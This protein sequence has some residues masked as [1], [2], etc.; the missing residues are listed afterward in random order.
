MAVNTEAVPARPPWYQGRYAS[1]LVTTD[2]KRVGILYVSTSLLFFLGGGVLALLMRS[3]LATAN[4]HFIVRGSYDELFTLHGTTMI[5]LVVVPILAGFGNFHVPLNIGEDLGR[6]P[7]TD[8]DDL[9]GVDAV[10]VRLVVAE[11]QAPAAAD[12]RRDR[13]VGE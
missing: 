9:L 8:G 3:Q 10:R 2:H 12:L 5:F 6:A 11:V 1:W 4:E 13:H 7:A